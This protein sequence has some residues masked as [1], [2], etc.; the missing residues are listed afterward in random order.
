M[1]LS[2]LNYLLLNKADLQPAGMV[3]RDGGGWSL[4]CVCVCARACVRARACARVLAAGVEK[5]PHD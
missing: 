4:A 3:R 1:A 5:G 2:S